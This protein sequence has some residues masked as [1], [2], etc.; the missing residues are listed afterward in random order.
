MSEINN[1]CFTYPIMMKWSQLCRC[2]FVENYILLLKLLAINLAQWET[3]LARYRILVE[4]EHLVAGD[5]EIP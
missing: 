1:L 3:N 2:F 4:R 5:I